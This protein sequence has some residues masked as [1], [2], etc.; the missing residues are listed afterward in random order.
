MSPCGKWLLTTKR[1]WISRPGWRLAPGTRIDPRGGGG[2]GTHRG[3]D[4]PAHF[5]AQHLHVKPMTHH[6]SLSP[7]SFA[8][9]VCLAL[10]V[11]CLFTAAVMAGDSE[12]PAWQEV[13]GQHFIVCYTEDKAFAETVCRKAEDSYSRITVELG[14]T[15]RD[16]FWTWKNRVRIYIYASK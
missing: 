12:A 14:F 10:P 8:L 11:V 1:T 13:K 2:G 6:S 9:Q 4:A 15:K 3:R 16:D 5:P 7:A